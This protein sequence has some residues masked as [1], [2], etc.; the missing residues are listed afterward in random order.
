MPSALILAR[1]RE[2][3]APQIVVRTERSGR[4]SDVRMRDPIQQLRRNAIATNAEPPLVKGEVTYAFPW[5]ASY[6]GPDNSSAGVLSIMTFD[7]PGRVLTPCPIYRRL[8]SVQ[9][10][11]VILRGPK[12]LLGFRSYTLSLLYKSV[13]AYASSSIRGVSPLTAFALLC[14]EPRIERRLGPLGDIVVIPEPIRQRRRSDPSAR[15]RDTPP[16]AVIVWALK[17]YSTMSWSDIRGLST[18]LKR[19]GTSFRQT[20]RTA[21][22]EPLAGFYHELTGEALPPDAYQS[23]VQDRPDSPEWARQRM[24]DLKRSSRAAKTNPTK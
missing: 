7:H 9:R 23:A 24:R 2:R 13:D 8:N 1:L 10:R 17:R 5:A 6:R 4:G 18:D 21:V 20:V 11:E 19:G 15:R 3:C 14:P 12:W 22:E 16:W